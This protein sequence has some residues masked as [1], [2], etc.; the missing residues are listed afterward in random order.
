MTEERAEYKSFGEGLM[1]GIK[2]GAE[3]EARI[4]ALEQVAIYSA[5]LALLKRLEWSGRELLEMRLPTLIKAICPICEGRQ[6][7]GDDTLLGG[8]TEDCELSRLIQA[9][10]IVLKKPA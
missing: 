7:V 4:T 1:A 2:S 5:M 8:H 3:I 6:P 9:L 10:E